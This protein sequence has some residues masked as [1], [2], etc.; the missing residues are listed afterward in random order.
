VVPV[1][2]PILLSIA[3][4]LATKSATSLYDLVKRKFAGRREAEAALDAAGDAPPDSPVVA[5]LAG[6]LAAEEAD[7]PAFGK[8]LRNTWQQVSAGR[9]GVVNQI[10]GTVSGKVVQARDIE[11]DISF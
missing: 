9:G 3:A 2:E 1:P 8:D 6:H 10:T 11:G 5:A 7:D 4:A